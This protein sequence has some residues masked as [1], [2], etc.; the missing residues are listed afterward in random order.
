MKPR[1][2]LDM[3][4]NT[5]VRF[6]DKMALMWKRDG[7]YRSLTYRGLWDQ[8]FHAASGLARLGVSRDDKVAIL[9]ASNPMWA[10]S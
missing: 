3:L 8:I 10:I 7:R 1:N 6:P 9:S 5:V 2:L 4:N